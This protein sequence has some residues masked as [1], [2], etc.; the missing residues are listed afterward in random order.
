MTSK[1]QNI[2]RQCVDYERVRRRAAAERR[3]AMSEV[4]RTVFSWRARTGSKR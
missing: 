3:R 4:M 2:D 1:P